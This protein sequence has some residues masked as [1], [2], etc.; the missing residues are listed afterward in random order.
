MAALLLSVLQAMPSPPR[1]WQPQIGDASASC[2]LVK[3]TTAWTNKKDVL[4]A[5]AAQCEQLQASIA[6]LAAEALQAKCQ[7][8]DA[9]AATAAADL[10]AATAAVS[11]LLSTHSILELAGLKPSPGLVAVCETA[12]EADMPHLAPCMKLSCRVTSGQDDPCCI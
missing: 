5:D 6:E 2:R 12:L 9:D 3:D 11:P 1:V 7:T 10:E 4:A 8:A